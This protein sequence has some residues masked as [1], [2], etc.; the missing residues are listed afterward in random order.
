MRRGTKHAS[1]IVLLAFVL[2]GILLFMAKEKYPHSDARAYNLYGKAIVVSAE[3]GE[4]VDQYGLHRGQNLKLRLTSGPDSGAVV[5]SYHPL[6][7]KPQDYDVL[8]SPGDRVI[9]WADNNDGIKTYH[10]SDFDRMPY[11]YVLAAIFALSLIYFGRVIGLKSLVGIAISLVLLWHWFFAYTLRPEFNVYVLAVGFCA[12]ISFF[13][14]LVVGGFSVKTEAA[15]LGTWGGLAVASLM[16]YLSIFFMHLTG[17]DTEEAFMLKASI[18]PFLDFRGVLFSSMIIGSLG[19]IIDVTISIAS[20][21]YEIHHLSPDISWKELYARGMNVGK[22]IMGAMSMTLIL[23]Y[24]GGSLP[25]LLV[26]A[27][28]R[29]IQLERVLNM[30]FVITELVR[31]LVGSVGLIYAIPLTALITATLLCHRRH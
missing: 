29:Q 23:A 10:F 20:S 26:I 17:L 19:A 14:L 22:D 31:A 15:I 4:S 2:A 6:A 9:V 13:A 27:V 30:P 16:S 28:D 25:L 18:A 12:V 5:E 8:L 24:V 1:L 21:Q 3:M 7:S 11:F